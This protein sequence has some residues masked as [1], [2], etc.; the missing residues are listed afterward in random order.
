MRVH[1]M[2]LIE[3]TGAYT[4]LEIIVQNEHAATA[5][6]APPTA[7]GTPTA[8]DEHA[9]GDAYAC[10]HGHGHGHGRGHEYAN[11]DAYGNADAITSLRACAWSA[12]CGRPAS[13]SRGCALD[14]SP[15]PVQALRDQG[16]SLSLRER[17]RVR[18]PVIPPSLRA[19]AT[20]SR[21]PSARVEA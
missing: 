3:T 19:C 15:D 17:V 9:Y 1:V 4:A 16:F 14:R 8:H 11:R 6:P 20:G 10:G 12:P 18:A 2:A 13:S 5:T 7:T 21:A